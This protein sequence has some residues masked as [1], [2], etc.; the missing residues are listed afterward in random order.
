M[1]NRVHESFRREATFEAKPHTLAEFALDDELGV[2]RREDIARGVYVLHRV[3]SSKECRRLIALAE[4]IGFTHAGLAI[5]DDTY[6]VNL[7]ARN[8][9]RV[10]LDATQLAA[11]LWSRIAAHVDPLHEGACVRGLNDRFRVYRYM[12][13]QRFSPHVDVRTKVPLGQ[14]RASLMIYLSDEFEGGETR[15]FETKDKTARRGEG[16]A[17]KFDNR[18]RFALRPA[19]GSVVVF[20]HLLL[21]EGAEVRAGVKYAVRSDLVYEPK[22]T[23]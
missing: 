11:R 18:V 10:V 7:A 1:R 14:T 13:G 5:G 12:P 23:Q 9:E 17:R 6:R 20:D 8:N 3:M 4:D 15:F 21:H 2:V 19:V 16:R 22:R